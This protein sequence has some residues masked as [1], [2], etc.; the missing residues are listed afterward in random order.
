MRIGIRHSVGVGPFYLS[1][2]RRHHRRGHRSTT[3][4]VWLVVIVAALAITFPVAVGCLLGAV[5]L[6]AGVVAISSHR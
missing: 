4:V 2:S 6:T 5:V 1:T 3:G